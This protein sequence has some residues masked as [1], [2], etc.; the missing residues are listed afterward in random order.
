MESVKYEYFRNGADC[1][2]EG[3]DKKA[4]YPGK[5]YCIDYFNLQIEIHRILLADAEEKNDFLVV[6]YSKARLNQFYRLQKEGIGD[7]IEWQKILEAYGR[8]AGS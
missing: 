2:L 7:P 8:D 4:D 1:I 6:P 3:A 5:D